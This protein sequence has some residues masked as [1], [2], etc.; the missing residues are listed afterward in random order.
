MAGELEDAMTLRDRG[1][2]GAAEQPGLPDEEVFANAA[3]DPIAARALQM[4][5]R[6][7]TTAKD[8]ADAVGAPLEEVS[9]H[10][11]DMR[12]SGL[13]LSVGVRETEGHSETVYEG[14]FIPILDKHE[15]AEL[16]P[17]ARQF[18][19]TEIIRLLMVDL[20]EAQKADTLDAWPD[21][22]LCRM[23]FHMDEQGWEEVGAV[24][25]EALIKAM[26][27]R[28]EATERLRRDG[29]TGKRGTLAQALFELP[30]D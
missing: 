29:K 24:Y 8:V 30:A 25:E 16:D 14:P 3:S 22:H 9:K 27:I 18:H 26:Q 2:P 6:R 12:R 19:L 17:A 21:F 15:R 28:E 13:I 10:L 5:V 1:K 20:D 11:V 7:P 23:P 4:M